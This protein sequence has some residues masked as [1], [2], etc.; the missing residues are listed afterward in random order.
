MISI[1]LYLIL[2]LSLEVT[3]QPRLT[4]CML[5]TY[6][7]PIIVDYLVTQS[8]LSQSVSLSVSVE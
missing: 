5:T 2:V 7:K 3:W 4:T 6:N 1:S 8:M